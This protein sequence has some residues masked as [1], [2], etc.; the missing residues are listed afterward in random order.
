VKVFVPLSDPEISAAFT[1]MAAKL[2]ESAMYAL[3]GLKVAVI[4]QNI[5]GLDT[6][7][8]VKIETASVIKEIPGML[9]EILT[10]RVGIV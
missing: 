9:V 2:P 7:T 3:A 6:C 1:E 8:F 10:S 4:A 5:V